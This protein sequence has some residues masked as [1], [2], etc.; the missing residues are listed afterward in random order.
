MGSG[1]RSSRSILES[2]GVLIIDYAVAD[3]AFNFASEFQ[4]VSLVLGQLYKL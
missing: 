3:K 1:Y 2:S 4:L